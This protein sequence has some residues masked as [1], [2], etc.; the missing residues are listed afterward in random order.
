MGTSWQL[1][2]KIIPHFKA[3]WGIDLSAFT[4]QGHTRPYKL[5][6][7]EPSLWSG[8]ATHGLSV[9]PSFQHINPSSSSAASM[10]LPPCLLI[11][12]WPWCLF[13][14][15]F[16]P[17]PSFLQFCSGGECTHTVMQL[18]LQSRNPTYWKTTQPLPQLPV[19]TF[20]LSLSDFDHSCNWSCS[21]WC[22]SLSKMSS[23]FLHDAEMWHGSLPSSSWMAFHCIYTYA[24]IYIYIYI[25][26]HLFI[27]P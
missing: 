8:L 25:F 15:S 2:G 19:T 23:T 13:A 6:Q 26:A 1:Q 3:F 12:L 9:I 4:A 21:E 16:S 20:P 7:P 17:S 5:P 24:C 22:I 10:S 18:I 27:C 11:S 14:D